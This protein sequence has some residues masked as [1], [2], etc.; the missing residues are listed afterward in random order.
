MGDLQKF[1][2]NPSW[3]SLLGIVVFFAYQII[4]K[5]IEKSN[6]KKAKDEQKKKSERQETSYKTIDRLSDAV[7]M[8]INKDIN[9]VNLI[10]AESI[11]TSKLNESKAIIEREIRRIFIQNHREKT[12]RQRIIKSAIKS[13]VIDT[14]DNDIKVFSNIFYKNKRLADFLTTID[15]D[16]L[17]ESIL[18]L[19]FTTGGIPESEL[20]DVVFLLD[21]SYNSY[22]L[23]G[24]KY[25]NNI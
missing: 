25:L 21:S 24:K 10:T 8:L 17:I 19:V 4:I 22:I 18:E 20:T 2:E 9:N 1:F 7:E 23:A 13:V 14:F 12:Q 6:E 16:F 5:E 11:I 3:I 15:P